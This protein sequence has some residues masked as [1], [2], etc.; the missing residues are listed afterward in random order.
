MTRASTSSIAD[1]PIVLAEWAEHI[2]NAT[3]IYMRH[4]NVRRWAQ[5][6]LAGLGELMTDDEAAACVGAD[7]ARVQQLRGEDADSWDRDHWAAAARGYHEARGNR[8]LE[9]EIAP[10]ELA[11]LHALLADQ[12]TLDRANAQILVHREHQRT[13]T[14]VLDAVVFVLRKGTAALAK[15]STRDRLRQLSQAQV[16]ACGDRLQALPPHVA[17]PWTIDE[18]KQLLATWRGCR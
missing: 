9:V 16:F 3:R 2:N 6:Y 1:V 17:K 15:S 4:A 18:I 8:R 10:H 12:I 5:G 13:A 14:S 7:I 11:R